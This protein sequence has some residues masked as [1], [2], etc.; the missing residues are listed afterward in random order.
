M[1]LERIK[2]QIRPQK[3]LSLQKSIL[4][5]LLN[6]IAKLCILKTSPDRKFGLIGTEVVTQLVEWLLPILE[7][8]GLN[9]AIGKFQ[10]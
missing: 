7:V 6:V 9:P 8:R 2:L 10:R 3:L 5:F 4:Y 1:D